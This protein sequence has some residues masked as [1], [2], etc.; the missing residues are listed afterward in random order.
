MKAINSIE[1][2]QK[3]QLAAPHGLL[4]R[5]PERTV[6]HVPDGGCRFSEW[7]ARSMVVVR[8]KARILR[9]AD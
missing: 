8:E 7:S 5:G 4:S 1:V 6:D 3:P 2:C 9:I